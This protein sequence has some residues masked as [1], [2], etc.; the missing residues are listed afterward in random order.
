M[1]LLVF[2]YAFPHWKTQ[3]GLVSMVTHGIRPDLVLLAPRK[4]LAV[5]Q[6]DYRVAPRGSDESLLDPQRLCEAL[7]LPCRVAAHEES[8]AAD[9]GVILGARILPRCVIDR[10]KTG[11]VNLHPG[12][13]PGNRG[14]DNLKHSIVDGLPIGVTAHFIDERVDMGRIIA[15]RSVPVYWDDTI[16]EVHLRQREAGQALM[17][18]T[19]QRI[20]TGPVPWIPCEHSE[21]FTVITEREDQFIEE[22]F[23][24]WKVENDVEVLR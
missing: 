3:Q 7:G 17:I 16:R 9:L 5:P 24:R 8:P 15:T 6:S 13:L 11:I 20:F 1:K 4:V 10:F 2:G 21:K 18:E 12:I 22:I 14:L 23:E 19:L